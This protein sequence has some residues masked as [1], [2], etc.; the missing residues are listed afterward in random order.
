[1]RYDKFA[2][3]LPEAISDNTTKGSRTCQL[4]SQAHVFN[5][6]AT[7]QQIFNR[8]ANMSKN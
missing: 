7:S 3:F 6:W 5:M 8:V 4:P 1:M 2:V